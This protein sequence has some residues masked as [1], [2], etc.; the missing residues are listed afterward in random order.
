[1][2]VTGDVAALP[3]GPIGIATGVEY[4]KEFSRSTFDALQQ[5]GLNAGNAIP[6]TKGGFDVWDY[7][8][9]GRFPIVKDQPYAKLLAATAAVRYGDYSTV[10]G[11]FSYS[12]GLEWA[13]NNDLRFR[14]TGSRATRAPNIAELFQ[15]PA[16]DFPTGLN[17]PCEGVT[18]ATG[19]TLGTRCLAAPGVASNVG[20][21]GAF[22][23]NQ[24]DV[25][26]IS[27]FDR[28]NPNVL[29]EEGKS[30]TL[31]LVFTPRNIN[32]LRNT[33]FTLDYWD[34]KID[35]AI[36]ST[37]PQFILDQC[38]TGDTSFCSFV[39]RRPTVEGANSA[40]S[41]EFIDTA[42]SN[43]GGIRAKGIDFT[44]AYSDRLG[45]GRFDALFS[46]THYLEGYVIPLPGADKDY[47]VGGVA[48]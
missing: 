11:T 33:A 41:L 13:L 9:E 31:G 27:G 14:G 38:Y 45:P 1:M 19:G 29:E 42:V 17:D 10:G 21:N 4:R 37:P 35:D 20:A 25:Q 12:L 39:T 3:A 40:G 5:A 8:L 36:V 15:A 28:G 22:T 16:Q 46:W 24:A 47:F 48:A 6:E 43:S 34:I 2:T 23:L 30:W 44:A 26:G 18:A 32:F 7:F